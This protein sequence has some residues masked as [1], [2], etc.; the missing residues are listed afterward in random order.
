MNKRII[1]VGI[2]GGGSGGSGTFDINPYSG[3][4]DATYAT[5]VQ[6]ANTSGTLTNQINTYS[7]YALSV[8]ELEDAW[9]NSHHD[10]NPRFIYTS[11][12]LTAINVYSGSAST[13]LLFSKSFSY[14][15]GYLSQYVITRASDGA[16]LTKNFTYVSGYLDKIVVVESL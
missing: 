13:D 11:G 6:L 9:K 5:K 8:R 7:G 2:S 12:Y 10:Y 1:Y 3:F 14:S 4:V 16:T 15:G